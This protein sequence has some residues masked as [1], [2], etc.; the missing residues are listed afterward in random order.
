[1]NEVIDK[2]FRSCRFVSIIVKHPVFGL[3]V[4]AKQTALLTQN[5]LLPI[6]NCSTCSKRSSGKRTATLSQLE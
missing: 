4:L 2:G 1:M 5:G 6:R 3:S